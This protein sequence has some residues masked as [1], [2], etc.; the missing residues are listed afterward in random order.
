[1]KREFGCYLVVHSLYFLDIIL[2][3]S[4]MSAMYIYVY[5]G[6]CGTRLLDCYPETTTRD[7]TGALHLSKEPPPS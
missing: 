2:F 5:M 7:Q 1:M 3:L 6:C 4:A